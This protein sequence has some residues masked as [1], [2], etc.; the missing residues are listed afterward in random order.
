MTDNTRLV[1][2]MIAR[3]VRM[4]FNIILSFYSTRIV[5]DA[6]GQSDY[7]IY[8]LVAGIVSLLTFLSNAM[9]TTTQRHLAYSIGSGNADRTSV[10]FD[11]SCILQW[12]IGLSFAIVMP[13]F[14]NL[15]FDTQFLNIVPE[16][17]TEAKYVYI[18][19][20]VSIIAT[21]VTTPYKAVLTAHENI[22][23]LSIIDI[24]DGVL[25]LCLVFLLYFFDSNRLPLYAGIMASITILHFFAL[26][27]YCQIHYKESSIIP[28]LR[29]WRW[30]IQNTLLG[31]ATWALY[32]SVCVI[33]RTQ[34][35]SILLNRTYGAIINAAFGIATQVLSAVISI[36]AALID[37]IAPQII[38]AEGA[39][40]RD[41]MLFLSEAA[42]KYSFLLLSI[43]VVPLC[44]EMPEVL[45]LW[46]D[47][48]PQHTTLFCRVIL[49]SSLIDQLT[50]GLGTANIAI[51]KIRNFSLLIYTVKLM[52]VPALWFCLSKGYG[53]TVAMA[54]YAVF[55]AISAMARIPFM[56]RLAGLKATSY[57]NNVFIKT[58]FPLA[59]QNA[60]CYLVCTNASPFI[61][62][63]IATGIL[64]ASAGILVIWIFT[65]SAGERHYVTNAVKNKIQSKR[66]K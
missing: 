45:K 27:I 23:Y 19:A 22:V 13:C 3:D 16:K 47:D 17:I 65:L 25:K 64:S 63:F 15:I 34:G 2:N 56:V 39:G 26:S 6:L 31:F 29:N 20:L 41:K 59:I 35:I 52:A 21:F 8:M 28:S 11:N 49:I 24:A 60:V 42:S 55:E 14:T 9:A 53:I 46:L 40:N 50:T 61:L 66:H 57:I 33:L 12:I 4:V 58:L 54:S 32:S 44:W 43:I 10:I 48:V 18:L 30:S 36:S 1:V 62:R 51:G 5:F 38:K 37:A 7:G